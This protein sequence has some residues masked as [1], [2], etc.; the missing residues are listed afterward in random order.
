MVSA[1]LPLPRDL[2]EQVQQRT[3]RRVRN[4]SVECR[5]G[6][7]VL[8]G[9]APSYYIKQLAQHSLLDALPPHWRLENAI[10]VTRPVS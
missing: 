7:V 2:E 4:L 10:T 9:Q 1:T 5:P 8:R 3:D 6:R